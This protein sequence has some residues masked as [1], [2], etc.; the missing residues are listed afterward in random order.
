MYIFCVCV[1]QSGDIEVQ[2]GVSVESVDTEEKV[3]QLSSGEKLSYDKLFLA[4]GAR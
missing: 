2:M 4:T 1:F 3:I